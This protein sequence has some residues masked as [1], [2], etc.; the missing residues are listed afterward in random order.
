MANLNRIVNVKIDIKTPAVSAAS[1]DNLLIVGPA[2]AVAP[3]TAPYPVGS[4]SDLAGVTDAGW[5]TTGE[6]ADPVGVA[7]R[8]AFSQNPQPAKIF[9]AVQQV[10]EGTVEAIGDTLNRALNTSGWY[11]ICPAG[12]AETDFNTIAEWTEA[13][14]KVFAFTYVG[15]QSPVGEIYYRSFGFDGKTEDTQAVTD[16]PDANRYLHVAATAKCLAYPSGSETW[17][18]KQ[19]AAVYP[20]NFSSTKC[21][22]LEQSHLNYFTEVGGKNITMNGQ[23]VAGE[24]IDVIRFRDWLQNDMQYRLYNLFIMNNKVPYTNSGIALIENQMIASL[25]AGQA[26]GGIAPDEYDAND[27]LVPGYTVTVPNSMDLSASEKASRALTG[28]KFSA[29][30]AGAIHAVTV[31]GELTY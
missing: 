27:S 17:A 26:A 28:C 24:W 14:T 13:Q 12:I 6:N 1:F 22:A 10:V 4:Y 31:N 2:P 18:F 9:I 29:R 3:T 8:I 21:D 16:V 20:S 15:A 19:L 5:V 30:L 23:V 7:A 11:V 25:K